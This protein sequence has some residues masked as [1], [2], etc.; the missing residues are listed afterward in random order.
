MSKSRGN[1]FRARVSRLSE[2]NTRV[3][4][5]N[6][7]INCQVQSIRKGLCGPL[8]VSH[9]VDDWFNHTKTRTNTNFEMF[10]C[11]VNVLC[12]LDSNYF[13]YKTPYEISRVNINR[14]QSAVSLKVTDPT[15]V[16][17]QRMI[18]GGSY[19]RVPPLDGNFR[20]TKTTF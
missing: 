11:N 13:K 7:K 16:R 9:I 1:Y 2:S 3:F 17:S 4:P 15:H 12:N 19:Q 14:P 8:P 18:R 20:V 6:N 10:Y 5:R